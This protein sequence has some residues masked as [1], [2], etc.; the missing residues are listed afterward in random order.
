MVNMSTIDARELYFGNSNT[1]DNR[2]INQNGY[3]AVNVKWYYPKLNENAYDSEDVYHSLINEFWK[4]AD[5][6]AESFNYDGC[7]SYGRSGGWA[8][9]YFLNK[10]EYRYI[11]ATS[12]KNIKNMIVTETFK[13]FASYIEKLWRLIDREIKVIETKEQLQQLTTRI[14]E[15]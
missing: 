15:L 9:P 14:E 13:S 6:I 4:K 12:D 1:L 5:E 8:I 3:L 7:H 2:Y 10:T 11:T